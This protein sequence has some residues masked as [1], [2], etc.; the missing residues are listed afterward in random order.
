MAR[1]EKNYA[2]KKKGIR[3]KKGPFVGPFSLP[4]GRIPIFVAIFIE[5]TFFNLSAD[6]QA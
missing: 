2:L 5:K 4:Q 1:R 6:G 3:L